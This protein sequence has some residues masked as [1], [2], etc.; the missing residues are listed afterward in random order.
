MRWEE[1]I[2]K[3]PNMRGVGFKGKEFTLLTG[4]YC[5]RKVGSEVCMHYTWGVEWE[6][7]KHGQV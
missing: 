4:P 6:L 7:E 1:R 2:E 3:V 5:F